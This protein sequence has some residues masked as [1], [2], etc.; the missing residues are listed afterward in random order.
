MPLI[1]HGE[2]FNT[3][4]ETQEPDIKK[5]QNSLFGIPLIL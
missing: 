5:E 1:T 3:I 4:Q 2:D